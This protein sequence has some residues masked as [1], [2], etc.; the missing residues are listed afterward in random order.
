MEGLS[1]AV[2]PHTLGAGFVIPVVGDVRERSD[3]MRE[4]EAER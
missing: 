4:Q 3:H 1:L 2:E